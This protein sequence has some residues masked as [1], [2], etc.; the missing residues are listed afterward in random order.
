MKSVA[1]LNISHGGVLEKS[2]IIKQNWSEM[3]ACLENA[4]G[5]ECVRLQARFK[6]QAGASAWK[7]TGV[8]LGNGSG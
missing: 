6:D 7:F 8:N 4:E 3:D 1:N 2:W 5:S